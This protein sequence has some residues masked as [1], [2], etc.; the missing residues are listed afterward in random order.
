MTAISS[1]RPVLLRRGLRL[2][3]VTVGWN[4]VE[5][6]LALGAALTAGAVVAVLD[7]PCTCMP[8]RLRISCT[9]RIA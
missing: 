1:D 5:G 2:E 9:I 6:L 4:V 3:Y 7:W 8:E